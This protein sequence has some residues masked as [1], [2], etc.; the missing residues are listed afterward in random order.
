MRQLFVFCCIVAVAT[1]Q[2]NK[3]GKI[4]S[5]VN[6]GLMTAMQSNLADE[7]T[8]CFEK[9]NTTSTDIVLILDFSGYTTGGFEMGEFMNKFQTI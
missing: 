4:L 9:A 2:M 3:I 1:A 5:D 6:L 7:G 8:T